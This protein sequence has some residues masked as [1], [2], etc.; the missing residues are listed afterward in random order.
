[1]RVEIDE[2]PTMNV[3]AIRHVGPYQGDEQLFGRL[4]GQLCAWAGPKGLLGP[5]NRFV[6]VYYDDPQTTPP[7]QLKIDVCLLVPDGTNGEADIA[8]QSIPG[9]LFAVASAEIKSPADYMTAWNDLLS[10]LMS[11]EY[12][13]DE[14]PSYELYEGDQSGTNR[15]VQLHLPIRAKA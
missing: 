12:E 4:F 1:M 5:N 11:S 6:S 10:W 7:E 14:R 8:T 13:M 3:A 9:G 2:L 15:T